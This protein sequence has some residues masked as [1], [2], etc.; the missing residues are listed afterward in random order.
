MSD[1]ASRHLLRN[2]ISLLGGMFISAGVGSLAFILMSQVFD[3]ETNPYIGMFIFTALPAV[4]VLG[5]VLV[6]VGM[7]WEARRQA[8]AARRGVGA[9]PALQ[10]DFGNPRHLRGILIFAMITAVIFG[11]MGATG[12]RTI[13]FMDSPAFCGRL[14]HTVMEP[15]Y[16]S[17]QRSAHAEVK[18][19]ACH[20]GPGASWYVKSKLGGMGQM[21]ATLLDTFPRPVPAPVKNLRPAR[22]TCEGCHWRE[23]A[24]GIFLRVYRSYLP[25]EKNSLH[26]RALAFRVGTGGSLLEEAGGVHWHT[27]AKLYYRTADEARQVVARV[28]VQKTDGAEEWVNPDIATDQPLQPERLMDCI[29]CHNRAAHKIP[30]PDQLI[31]DALTAGRLDVSLPYLKREALQLMGIHD[32]VVTDPATAAAQWKQPGWF[33]QLRDFYRTNYPDVA[34]AKDA[35]ISAAID[36]LKRISTLVYYPDMNTSWLTYPDNRG[37]AQ[38]GLEVS[39]GCFRCHAKLVSVTS[40]K[41]L[42]GGAG[43]AGCLTCHGLGSEGQ[44]QEGVN[45]LNETAC[46]YCHVPIP[47]TELERPTPSS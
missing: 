9:P 3:V 6:P 24:H 37:H 47:I 14:C 46:S 1:T 10:L 30:A 22:A 43:G 40:G 11:L 18:C 15:E 34:A 39:T 27:S 13:E 29:D 33:E 35:S 32:T 28:V 44:V 16:A 23:Q 17:Y 12:Y 7:L 41:Q 5:L 21:V 42:E 26:A 2:P 36:E 25:D 31:D 20:I 4:L 38:G 19:T 45:P 8:A